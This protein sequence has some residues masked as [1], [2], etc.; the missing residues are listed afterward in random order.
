MKGPYVGFT[1]KGNLILTTTEEE[2]DM[3]IKEAGTTLMA[4]SAKVGMLPLLLAPWLLGLLLWHQSTLM[5]WSVIPHIFLFM[6]IQ[7]RLF[8]CVIN[9]TAVAAFNRKKQML[10]ELEQEEK[11]TETTEEETTK[12]VGTVVDV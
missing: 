9:W 5:W 10:A 6:G 3:H 12:E 4:L 1:E 7:Y 8:S 11:Q 2:R